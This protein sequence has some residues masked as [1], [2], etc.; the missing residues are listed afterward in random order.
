[1]GATMQ[2]F[3]CEQLY[4]RFGSVPVIVAENPPG[5]ASG[6]KE[7]FIGPVARAQFRMKWLH[8]NDDLLA[9][10]LGQYR[11]HYSIAVT[12][13][14]GKVRSDQYMWIEITNA[15][16]QEIWR[17][18][19]ALTPLPAAISVVLDGAPDAC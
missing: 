4:V 5:T 1:M 18:P 14:V 9:C 8:C 16:P 2:Q 10:N 11:I 3:V 6:A 12:G 7:S 15:F 17:E 19:E 13:I